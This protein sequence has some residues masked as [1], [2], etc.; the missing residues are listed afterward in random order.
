MSLPPAA[1]AGHVCVKLTGQAAA[2]AAL[3]EGGPDGRL[4]QLPPV[5][6]QFWRT[7]RKQTW[8]F[9]PLRGATLTNSEAEKPRLEHLDGGCFKQQ[10][11]CVVVVVVLM[12]TSPVWL[13]TKQL[14]DC[15][16]PISS[17]NLQL[18][19]ADGLF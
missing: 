6:V 19:Q 3:Q 9:N 1:D 8:V 4:E 2:G 11:L 17:T 10:K 12:V 7:R 18:F 15:Q 16:T 14:S 5:L 13:R